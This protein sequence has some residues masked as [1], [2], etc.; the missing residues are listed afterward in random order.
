MPYNDMYDCCREDDG[1]YVSEFNTTY[2]YTGS[3][4]GQETLKLVECLKQFKSITL[5]YKDTNFYIDLLWLNFDNIKVNGDDLLIDC[6]VNGDIRLRN[7]MTERIKVYEEEYGDTLL[8]EYAY[9]N[10]YVYFFDEYVD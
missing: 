4:K 7:F 5:Q 9:D 3:Y 1:E 8:I 10:I 6:G 2:R